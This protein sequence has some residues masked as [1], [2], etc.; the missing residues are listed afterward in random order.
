VVPALEGTN[1]PEL[2][3]ISHPP[4]ISRK[5]PAEGTPVEKN[6]GG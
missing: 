6:K 4:A 2:S 1:F 3:L 5:V